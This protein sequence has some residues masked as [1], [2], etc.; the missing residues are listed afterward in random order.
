M[1]YK[2]YYFNLVN[3]KVVWER[4]VVRDKVSWYLDRLCEG[5][6]QKAVY[7]KIIYICVLNINN[8]G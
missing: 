1:I 3:I 4:I 5:D 2:T 7:D 6:A 8:K